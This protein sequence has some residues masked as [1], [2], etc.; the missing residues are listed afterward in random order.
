MVG[1]HNEI[2]KI[3]HLAKIEQNVVSKTNATER[4]LNNEISKI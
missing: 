1:F 2:N 4:A 3:M